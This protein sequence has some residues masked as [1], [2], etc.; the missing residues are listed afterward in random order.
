MNR[1]L[2]DHSWHQL[3]RAI[4]SGK[5]IPFVGAGAS[6]P[7]LPTA[8]E[9][10]RRLCK[11]FSIPAWATGDLSRTAEFIEISEG[12]GDISHGREVLLGAVADEIPR[13]L[14]LNDA[15][16]NL[17]ALPW[18][19]IVTTNYDGF[20]PAALYSAGRNAA[21]LSLPSPPDP[22]TVNRIREPSVDMPLIIQAHGALPGDIVITESDYYRYLSK[23][24]SGVWALPT[25]VQSSLASSSYLFVGYS[26]RDWTFRLLFYSLARFIRRDHFALIFLPREA[27]EEAEHGVEPVFPDKHHQASMVRE[28]MVD[29]LRRFVDADVFFGDAQSFTFE[30]RQRWEE[31]AGLTC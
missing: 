26:V 19:T 24:A 13:H 1:S 18:H 15:H 25:T 2:D 7:P 12:G 20:L 8:T 17:A 10:C 27:D 31:Y 29:Y 14:G 9:L 3:L 23:M 5:C 16:L 28:Y 11:R 4:A 30:L 21:V 22:K 6:C